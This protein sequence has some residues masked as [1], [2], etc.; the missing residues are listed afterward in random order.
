MKTR[1]ILA[2]L[3]LAI[4]FVS[5]DKDNAGDT[6]KPEINL[7]SPAEGGVLGATG[8]GI[9][10]EMELS[11]DVALA[12]Y[13]VEIHNNFD[14]HEH[15]TK[16]DEDTVDFTYLNTWTD[17]AGQRNATIHHH[18]IVIPTNATHGD[19]HFIVYCVD[20]AGNESYVVHNITIEDEGDDHDHDD[21]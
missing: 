7:I 4:T 17:M 18:E 13:K 2:T 12:S 3:L 21:E 20:E 1:A 16:S 9:H 14:G 11:D 8:E 6:T 15:T 19:Y 5:C 10:F